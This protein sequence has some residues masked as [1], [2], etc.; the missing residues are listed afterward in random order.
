MLA[1][2]ASRY[3]DELND[4]RASE[5]KKTRELEVQ[6][7]VE[8]EQQK[9]RTGY[10]APDLRMN[11][12]EAEL[13]VSELQIVLIIVVFYSQVMRDLREWDGKDFDVI[14]KFVTFSFKQLPPDKMDES[15]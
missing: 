2:W 12:V 8:E 11:K 7:L 3:N 13:R 6:M 1:E 14:P 4:L 5:K 10:Q 9:L 15:D